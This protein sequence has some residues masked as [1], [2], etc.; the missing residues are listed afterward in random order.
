MEALEK[1]LGIL[2]ANIIGFYRNYQHVFLI[3]VICM[4]IVLGIT[5]GWDAVS[6]IGTIGAVCVSLYLANNPVKKGELFL[7]NVSCIVHR[8]EDSSGKP[9]AKLE[10]GQNGEIINSQNKALGSIEVNVYLENVGIIPIIINAITFTL[11]M[12]GFNNTEPFQLESNL[13]I[14]GEDAEFLDF[15]Y[16]LA[17]SFAAVYFTDGDFN[18]ASKDI[19]NLGYLTIYLGD[20]SI[21]HSTFDNVKFDSKIIY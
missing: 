20:G 3:I 2:S 17:G 13:T 19:L 8:Y 21:I 6:A 5:F 14:R 7:K 9:L 12:N 15:N 16:T 4:V 18:D 1:N 11:P 10:H